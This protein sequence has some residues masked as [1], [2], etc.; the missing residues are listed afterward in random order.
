MLARLDE[1]QRVVGAIQAALPR[2]PNAEALLRCER[3]MA[4][5]FGPTPTLDSAPKRQ[6]NGSRSSGQTVLDPSPW[7][8]RLAGI[9]RRFQAG[10]SGDK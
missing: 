3:R 1:T 10:C 5:L 6:S 2:R 8:A 7:V 9:I 4:E